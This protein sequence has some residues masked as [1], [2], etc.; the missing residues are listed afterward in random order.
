M[1][2][3]TSGTLN[4]PTPPDSSSTAYTPLKPSNKHETMM[5]VLLR[6]NQRAMA[7]NFTC[8]QQLSSKVENKLAETQ[9]YEN[10]LQTHHAKLIAEVASIG[11]C[12][13]I[14]THICFF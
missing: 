6:E 2:A 1:P 7:E 9:M 14:L 4:T 13:S 8:L 11:K 3:T 10:V 12:S 5:H